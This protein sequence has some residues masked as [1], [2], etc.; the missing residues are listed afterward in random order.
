MKQNKCWALSTKTKDMAKQNKTKTKTCLDEYSCF[1][2]QRRYKFSGLE[3]RD[4]PRQTG[5]VGHPSWRSSVSNYNG[6]LQVN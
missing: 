4:G 5:T 2:L 6:Y 1:W 3:E